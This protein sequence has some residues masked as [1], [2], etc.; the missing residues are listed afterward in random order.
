MGFKDLSLFNDVLLAKQVWRLLNNK[1][2]LCYRVFKARFFP[3][4]SI[5]EASDSNHGSYAWKSLLKGQEVIKR[6]ARW[7]IGTGMRSVQSRL[8]VRA[9][10]AFA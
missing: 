9:K 8:N 6:G 1:Q 5:M 7:R 3:H 10:N 2:F 4:C